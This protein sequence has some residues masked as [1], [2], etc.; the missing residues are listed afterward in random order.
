M[1]E[2]FLRSLEGKILEYNDGEI[3]LHFKIDAIES[4]PTTISMKQYDYRGKINIISAKKLSAINKNFS[5]TL[6]KTFTGKENSAEKIPDILL[7]KFKNKVE[8]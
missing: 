1:D 6:K 7:A 3:F 4:C 8:F 5:E 2:N